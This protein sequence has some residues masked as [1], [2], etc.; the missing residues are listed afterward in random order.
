VKLDQV[1]PITMSQVETQNFKE[2][3]AHWK[4]LCDGD[5]NAIPTAEAFDLI[6]VPNALPDI[7]YWDFFRSGDIICRFAGT[8]ITER[9]RTEITGVHLRDIMPAHTEPMIL[10]DFRLMI[11]HPCGMRYVVENKHTSGKIVRLQSISLPLRTESDSIARVIFVN[12]MLETLGFENK[13]PDEGLLI[14]QKFETREPYDL[15][16]G[17]PSNLMPLQ[18]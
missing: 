8:H 11:S 12:N 4:S 9:T 2:V 13:V 5:D 7:T 10:D 14:G 18:G 3:F 16:W 6:A 15:G 1:N 17:C